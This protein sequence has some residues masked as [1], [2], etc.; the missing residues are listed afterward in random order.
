MYCAAFWS[1]GSAAK[2]EYGR[3]DCICTKPENRNPRSS[4]ARELPDEASAEPVR[5]IEVRQA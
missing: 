2:M 5:T 4:P 1:S 3:P